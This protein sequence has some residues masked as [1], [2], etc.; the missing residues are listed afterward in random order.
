M[1]YKEYTVK[2]YA[3]GTKEWYLNGQL[4]REDGPAIERVDGYKSWWLNGVM[5]S[6]AEFNAR[7]NPAPCD[8]KIVEIEGRKYELRE[9]NSD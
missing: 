5:L 6:E 7:M 2:V 1:S 8:G 9:V 3:D 4:H